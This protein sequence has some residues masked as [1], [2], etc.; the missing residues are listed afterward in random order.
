PGTSCAIF[1]F[2]RA[3][4]PVVR[5]LYLIPARVLQAV[6][7]LAIALTLLFFALT[8]TEVGRDGLRHQIER[9]FAAT[10]E[11]TLEIGGLTGNLVYD[12]TATD[13]RLRDPQGR[14]VLAADSVLLSPT[15]LGLLQRRLV[16]DEATP[17]RPAT[18]PVRHAGRP[19]TLAAALA[20][21]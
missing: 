3:F 2:L 11:G 7:L 8:R 13:V 19:R 1:P 14:T 10:Y 15:W 16:L 12:L 9:A 5:Y 17:P 18:A 20:P 6:A 21:R 4:P